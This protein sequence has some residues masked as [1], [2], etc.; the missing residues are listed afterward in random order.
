VLQCG[1][2]AMS[3]LSRPEPGDFSCLYANGIELPSILIS[4]CCCSY[5]LVYGFGVEVRWPVELEVLAQ[6]QR[7]GGHGR[8]DHGKTEERML[9]RL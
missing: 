6:A 9:D 5:L 8:Q 4:L 3:V 2:K 1:I 7:N